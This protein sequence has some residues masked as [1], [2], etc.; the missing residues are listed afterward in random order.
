MEEFYRAYVR[1]GDAAVS[2]RAAMRELR[3]RYPHPYFWAP[4]FLT[5]RV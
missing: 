1:S 4:F 5:G 3:M 2:L